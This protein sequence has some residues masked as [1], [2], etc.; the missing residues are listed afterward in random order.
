[1]PS[2][3]V[4][5]LWQDAKTKT[6]PRKRKCPGCANLMVEVPS[7]VGAELQHLDVCTVCQFVWFDPDEY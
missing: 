3:V 5:V 6:Y 7:D 4:N 1:M 2:F